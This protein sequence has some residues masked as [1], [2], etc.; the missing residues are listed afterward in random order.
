M[1]RG[2]AYISALVY[3]TAIS[4]G[5]FDRLPY[6][7]LSKLL[8][9]T[10]LLLIF[11]L[12]LIKEIRQKNEGASDKLAFGLATVITAKS[13]F[14]F[15]SA[16]QLASF[17]LDIFL[18]IL[19]AVIHPFSLVLICAAF[20]VMI[21][22]VH[23]FM[24]S[25][26][27]QLS[28]NI[29]DGIFLFSI[30][31]FVKAFLMAEQKA[32]S[33]AE[34]Q[35]GSIASLA[36]KISLESG[37]G[38]ESGDLAISEELKENIFLDSAYRLNHALTDTLNTIR[39]ITDAYSCCLF[40]IE[41]DAFRLCAAVSD[42]KALKS[43]ILRQN[44][45]NQL[46]WID[47]NDQPHIKDRLSS[48]N[49]LGY[50]SSNED[51]KTFIGL[52]VSIGEGGSRAILCIDGQEDSFSKEDEKI[53]LLAGSTVAG[54]LKSS[55]AMDEMRI[56][57]REFHSFYNFTKELN[58]SL[59]IE[60][61]LDAALEFS[62]KIVETDLSAIALNE[63]GGN[64]KFIKAKG[65][66]EVELVE[67]KNDLDDTILSRIMKQEKPF[68]FNREMKVK[69][70]YH[71]FPGPLLQMGTFLAIP[72]ILGG[73]PIGLYLTARLRHEPF[74]SYEIRLFEAMSAHLSAAISN[75]TMYKKMENMA[76]TD[77]LT[78][79]N[80]HRYFQE[81]LGLEM[82]R[83]DRYKDKISL[84]LTDIDF[85][86]K[87]NDGY[88][89]PAGDA[90]IKGVAGILQDAIRNIDLAARYGGEEFTVI[91]VNTDK[92]EALKIGQ[93]IRTTIEK[94]KFDIGEGKTLKITMSMGIAVFPTDA[95]S[96]PE[97][98]SKAD[99]TLYLAKTEGRNKTY[100]YSDVSERIGKGKS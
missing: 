55:A 31:F 5:F 14:L 61:M 88:G 98:I 58:S 24:A 56:E 57:A 62:S 47:E 11:L 70:V 96:K 100:A 69:E 86:K 51:I 99:E 92:K 38:E 91:L 81:R 46:S 43:E 22:V 44:G 78:G 54:H 35:L 80:N 67:S 4:A 26:T 83:S 21:N 74:T 20:I 53:L 3:G 72:L 77:G 82:E 28:Q 2:L 87:V 7:D 25:G 13:I 97:L 19:L 63:D 9:F 30:L 36:E 34:G 41:E 10:P 6:A 71:D 33:R 66:K 45:K 40:M 42:S 64:L 90:I 48:R 95:V 23:L 37:K 89:H 32:K 39:N 49:S 79:L 85:F 52:P 94:T 18:L 15:L 8:T 12:T 29:Y 1:I 17:P 76:I 93:R 65:K 50:Y 75:A 84:I 16:G 60:L 68:H 73:E 27:I 59:D